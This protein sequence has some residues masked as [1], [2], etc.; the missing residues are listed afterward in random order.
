MRS[1]CDSVILTLLFVS[2][3]VALKVHL[4]DASTR[5]P[6]AGVT[7]E[8][9]TN[10]TSIASDISGADGNAYIRFPYRLG[11][12]LVVTATKRGYVPNSIPWRPNRLPGN[13]LILDNSFYMLI[14]SVLHW[15]YLSCH[16]TIFFITL[17][18][19]SKSICI[20]HAVLC[21]AMSEFSPVAL[22]PSSI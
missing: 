2:T 9:F 16:L 10:H 18:Y 19:V 13:D 11:D 15:G 14:S 17:W 6:L 22:L 20:F 12:L 7:A 8:I 3:E 1:V 5:Q 21:V 4:S